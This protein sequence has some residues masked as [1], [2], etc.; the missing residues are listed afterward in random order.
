VIKKGDSGEMKIRKEP[1][2]ERRA[3]L[4]QIIEE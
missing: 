4:T 1:I 3:D 2:P